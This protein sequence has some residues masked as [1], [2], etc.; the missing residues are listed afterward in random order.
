MKNFVFGT[1]IAVACGTAALPAQTQRIGARATSTTVSGVGTLVGFV[2]PGSA[3][4]FRLEVDVPVLAVNLV[5]SPNV[6]ANILLPLEFGYRYRNQDVYSGGTRSTAVLDQILAGNVYVRAV[7][8]SLDA[9]VGR[10]QLETEKEATFD[11]DNGFALLTGRMKILPAASALSVDD[12]E[13]T[14]PIPDST[15]EIVT[16]TPQFPGVVLLTIDFRTAPGRPIPVDPATIAAMCSGIVFCRFATDPGTTGPL[17]IGKVEKRV[18]IDDGTDGPTENAIGLF[19]RQP[20]GFLAG[21]IST[22]SF[23]VPVTAV[24]VFENGTNLPFGQVIPIGGGQFFLAPTVLLTPGQI[25]SYE[26]NQVT[27]ELV[28]ATA[29]FAAEISDSRPPVRLDLGSLGLNGE[30]P[31]ATFTTEPLIEFGY[32]IA[33]T[34]ADP[35]VPAIPMIG[36]DLHD[37]PQSLAPFGLD[38]TVSVRLLTTLPIQLLDGD[39]AALWTQMLPNDTSLTGLPLVSQVAVLSGLDGL[40]ISTLTATTVGPL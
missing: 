6:N 34:H 18:A 17:V 8:P 28:T 24:N 40:T 19:V 4:A 3:G 30:M 10:L 16:G 2:Q 36:F 12:P 13:A 21:L 26:Q 7:T 14:A 15:I 37:P 35:N 25:A 32:G 38:D 22:V 5:D 20:G 23:P 27:V 29:T 39:G 33:I 11:L 9:L 31:V 1:L